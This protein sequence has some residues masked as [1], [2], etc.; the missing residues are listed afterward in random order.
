MTPRRFGRGFN[1]HR[2]HHP[3]FCV[4][5]HLGVILSVKFVRFAQ[6]CAQMCGQMCA[7]LGHTTWPQHLV[8]SQA[9]MD[10]LKRNKIPACDLVEP[11][12]RAHK[13]GGEMYLHYDGHSSAKG[14]VVVSD[15][16]EK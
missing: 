8:S 12:R 4:S 6:M 9:V 14:H 5:N 10:V 2:L 11:L 7:Q 1:S 15:A 13:A 3:F 16:L